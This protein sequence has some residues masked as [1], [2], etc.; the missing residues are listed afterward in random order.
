MKLMIGSL[1]VWGV[2]MAG[3]ASWDYA[4]GQLAL[5]GIRIAG[6]EAPL[7]GD[8][9]DLALTLNLILGLLVGLFMAT[10]AR[11]RKLVLLGVMAL[12]AAGVIASFSRGGFLALT[13]VAVLFVGKEAKQ[14]GPAVLGLAL[15][16]LVLAL[17]AL[18]AGYGDRIRSIFD[19]S[20]DAT[21]SAETRWQG[22]IVGLTLM[23]DH[24]LLGLGLNMHNIALAERGLG[25]N[26]T[27][28]A[29]IQV[30]AD[31]GVAGFLLYVLL[32]WQLFRDV[33]RSRTGLAP[34]REGREL[35]GLAAGVETA[36]VA[37]VVGGALLPVAYRFYGFYIAGFA[38][39]VGEIARPLRG[40]R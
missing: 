23:L 4:T 19:T 40:Q 17:I 30:G 29:F 11:V 28:S 7:T 39:A 2:I 31:L 24:P 38:V 35:L 13:V 26:P 37:F 32:F 1:A 20:A 21:G 15:A 6:Y 22:M 3:T 12:L 33:R 18:P 34:S 5:D 27:H 10:Q 36:L 8:P 9:N 14:R 25:W 16:L